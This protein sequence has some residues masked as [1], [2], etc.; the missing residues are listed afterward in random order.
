MRIHAPLGKKAIPRYGG[1]VVRAPTFTHDAL[2]LDLDNSGRP[3][4][5]FTSTEECSI[6]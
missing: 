1:Y 6:A 4:T 3:Q 2:S 5:C